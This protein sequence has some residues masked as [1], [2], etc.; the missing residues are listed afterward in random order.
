MNAP[1]IDARKWMP[2]PADGGAAT[3]LYCLPHAG[4]GASTY[5][6][7]RRH[8]LPEVDV[9][10]LQPPGREMRLRDE[11]FQDLTRLLDDLLA[12]MDGQWRPPFAL[13][14][15]SLGALVA[16]ELARRLQ[17]AGGPRPTHLIVSGRRAPQRPSRLPWIRLADDEMLLEIVR[18]LGGTPDE[19]FA[20]EQMR[21]SVLT[22]M[23]ADL[24]VDQTYRYRPDPPLDVPITVLSGGDDTHVSMAELEPWTECGSAG[25]DIELVPGG[26]FFVMSHRDIVIR[27]VR[28]CL[29]RPS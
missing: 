22:L 26:H 12:A 10:P 18:M 2:Y 29:S 3:T 6:P 8:L 23:R 20:D 19:V 13:F 28:H 1:A 14:G 21:Q 4:A 7:W 15:H 16:Y 11:P 24:G 25:V 17:A 9:V 5:L 27:R